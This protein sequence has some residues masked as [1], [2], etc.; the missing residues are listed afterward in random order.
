MTDNKR[1]SQ[2]AEIEAA[3]TGLTESPLYEYRIENEYQPVIGEGSL[4]AEIMFIGEAP[5]EKEA[6]QG[7]PFVGAAGK[8]LSDLLESIGLERADVYITNIVKDRPPKN[9]DPRQGEIKLYAPF[10]V[11]QIEIIQP[12]VLAPLGRF[13]MD[14]ILSQFGIEGG[15]KIGQVH[16]TVI[17]A[18][19]G[20]GPV[21]IVPLYHPAAGFYN[22]TLQ[23]ALWEDIQVLKQFVG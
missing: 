8:V 9:R 14:F 4:E 2:M 15:Q 22:R 13:S 10:L 5:G 11:Q 1:H 23:T 16:G 20:Y 12:N 21:A 18:E 7:R 17:E 3:V 6:Q 19:A